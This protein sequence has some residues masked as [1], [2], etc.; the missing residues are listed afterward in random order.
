MEEALAAAPAAGAAIGPL[1][2]RCHACQ[3]PTRAIGPRDAPMGGAILA[4]IAPMLMNEFAINL[5][6]YRS[7]GW[8]VVERSH[9]AE[10]AD[11]ARTANGNLPLLHHKFRL[12]Q[13]RHLPR[14]A[15][16]A[17]PVEPACSR[18]PRVEVQDCVHRSVPSSSRPQRPAD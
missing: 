18:V 14:L 10:C 15:T 11:E 13:L 17:V 5:G 4:L 7:E 16:A 8:K 12:G 2:A 9:V 6:T 1:E 3:I